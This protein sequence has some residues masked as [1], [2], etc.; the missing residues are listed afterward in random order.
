MQA[1]TFK[2]VKKFT[3][4]EYINKKKLPLQTFQDMRTE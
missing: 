3:Y 2:R 4:L 1:E